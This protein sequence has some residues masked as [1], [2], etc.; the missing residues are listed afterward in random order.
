MKKKFIFISLLFFVIS[1]FMI[2][3]IVFNDRIIGRSLDFP[4]PPVDYLVKN[5][6]LMNFYSWWGAM[7]GGGRNSFGAALIPANSILYF[8][9]LFN[10]GTWFIGRYQI[11]LTL[12]TAMLSFYCLSRRFMEEYN[13]EE[14]NKII[15]SIIASLF[16]VFNGYFFCDIIFGSN[17]MY[18]TYS[19]IPLLLYFVITY[20][21]EQK[22][23]YF[24][25][26]LFSIIIISSTL[27]NLVMA[28]ILIFLFS[29]VHKKLKFFVKLS[30]LHFFLS[31]YWILPLFYVSSEVVTTE[32]KSVSIPK[33]LS[34]SLLGSASHFID[35]IIN[36]EY[37]SRRNTYILGLNNIFL[38]YLWISNA[39][40]LLITSLLILL[41]TSLAKKNHRKTILGLFVILI[42]SLLFMKG[43]HRPFGKFVIYLY[44]NFPFFSL[45]RSLQHYIGFYVIS[46]S[47]LF[48]FSG[49]FLINKNRRFLYLLF[50][51]VLIN[52]M[53]WWYTLDLGTKN[54]TTTNKIPSYFNEY[55]LTKG[56]KKMYALNNLPL[57][58][59]VLHAP[60][61]NSI[62]F[63]AIGE[64]N[65]NFITRP[66]GRIKSQGVDC[67]LYYGNKRF[68]A[69][70]G[71]K[72][73]LSDILDNMEEDMYLNPNFF[74]ENK[75]LLS[76][77]GA[78]YFV[79][80][81]DVRPLFP[82]NATLF[83]LE[84]VKKTIEEGEL[85][86]SI[87]KEDF[88]TIAKIQ[89]F[90]PHF[91]TPDNV[92][93]TVSTVESL[94]EIV[95]KPDYQI[96]SAIYFEA[97]NENKLNN[98]SNLNTKK[99]KTAII[100]FKKINPTKYRV[101]VHQ[102]SGQFPLVF[103]ES[104]HSQWKAYLTKPEAENGN[105]KIKSLD[106]YTIFNEGDDDQ[107]TKEELNEFIDQ[108]WI[109]ALGNR[110]RIAFVSKNFQN[111]IQNDNLPAGHLFETW[112]EKPISES[113]HLT[114]NG[115]ANSWIINPNEICQAKNFCVKNSDGT[116][117]FELTVEFWPQRLLYIGL[118]ISG[119]TLLAFA[120]YIIWN[121]QRK[122][123]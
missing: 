11:V 35:T 55:Y 104:F 61:G 109:S 34:M 12:F 3:R 83:N 69:T 53:P 123:L 16:F 46:I 110:E 95:S 60:P 94:P 82:K 112:F 120:S 100:E 6:Y 25:L 38:S 79:I 45:F 37:F 87:E 42:F 24:V 4:I 39:F 99:T 73:N 2:S 102:A 66:E 65:F 9:L 15:L 96:R 75:T 40:I 28:Y 62:N 63:L 111:T 117:D 31:L 97:Q 116:Y 74:E 101:W 77:L 18:F 26:S 122:N 36:K 50:G 8:P 121:L 10:A 43:G 119:T 113:N 93:V 20:F 103:G 70:D 88:V 80:R 84:N 5:N 51:L 52:A 21:K 19:L 76:L 85:F 89:N 30:L 86:S 57:D 17:A 47:I 71:P 54:I 23:I 22:K 27:Q 41:K 32:I 68:F 72:N 29:V 81:E 49:L 7:N 14:K 64:N 91:Y 106:K 108:D 78:R 56:D 105:I 90:L 1:I 118:F 114:V 92:I 13:L 115:Y 48:L 67:G 33:N 59:A 98:L 107:A 44:Q 58:F